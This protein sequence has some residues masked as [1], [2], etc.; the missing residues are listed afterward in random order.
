MNHLSVID[1][2]QA[3]GRIEVEAGLRRP[4]VLFLDNWTLGWKIWSGRLAAAA[5]AHATLDS[6]QV[7]FPEE[8]LMKVLTRR[9]PSPIGRAVTTREAIWTYRL[10]R[11]FGRDIAAGTFDAIFTNA[12]C[13][14]AGVVDLCR[15]SGTP[16]VVALDT[17]GPTYVRDL[18]GEAV[19]AGQ[20]WTAEQAIYDTA[21][22]LVPVSTWAADSLAADFGVDAGRICLTLPGV[23]LRRIGRR[24]DRSVGLPRLLFVGNC[25]DR[26]GGP[27]L[28]EWHQRLWRDR[29]ELHVVSAKAPVD[30]AARNVVWH[31]EVPN[32]RVLGELLP[33]ADVFCLP[34]RHDMSGFAIAEAQA[35]GVPVVAS[36]LAGIKDLVIDAETGYLIDPH[37]EA[38]F[39]AA[40]GRL[41]DDGPLRARMGVAA[42]H[43]AEAAL[44]AAV[45]FPRLLD[46]V[47]AV[48]AAR[49]VP[50]T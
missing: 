29:A 25:W 17:T 24:V 20:T 36:R 46:R 35:A 18:L 31:G 43:H 6:V 49:R 23:D 22:L 1:K 41:L 2:P 3:G 21:A 44:D 39:T 16:L 5:A 38:G 15:R 50:A 45:V 28:L 7:R 14:A 30:R 26:K 47:E 13:L 48:C 33:S 8:F 11:R 40:I 4:R 19:P 9:L 32:D 37:D 10:R 42:R 27:E 12:Q 34:T